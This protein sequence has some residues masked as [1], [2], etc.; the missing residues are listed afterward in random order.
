MINMDLTAES[1]SISLSDGNVIPL[2]GPGTYGDPRKVGH[3]MT[4]SNNWPLCHINSFCMVCCVL[5]YLL[6][7][8]VNLLLFFDRPLKGLHMNQSSWLL[9][10]DT[11]TSMGPCSISMN[12]RWEK[13]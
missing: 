10:H 5:Y 12:M 9:T 6:I 3:I 2:I 13:L 4:Q 8:C 11:D 1:H 7:R